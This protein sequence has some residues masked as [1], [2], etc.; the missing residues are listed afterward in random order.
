MSTSRL[1]AR[2]YKSTSSRCCRALTRLISL[3]LGNFPSRCLMIQS[4]CCSLSSDKSTTPSIASC[5]DG[6]SL[7]IHSSSRPESGPTLK[8]PSNAPLKKED[9][10]QSRYLGTCHTLS[11]HFTLQSTLRSSSRVLRLDGQKIHR[12]LAEDVPS[13]R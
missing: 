12:S 8:W 3:F 13:L 4:R 11:L 1:R 2:A 6:V 10:A 7:R 9:C 5:R